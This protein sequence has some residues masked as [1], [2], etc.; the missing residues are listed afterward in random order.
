MS[1]PLVDRSSR[2]RTLMVIIT[3]MKDTTTAQ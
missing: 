1:R 2:V 3:M